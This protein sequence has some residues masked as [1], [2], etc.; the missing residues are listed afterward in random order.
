MEGRP[1]FAMRRHAAVALVVAV[2]LG[3]A[4][5]LG[6]STDASSMAPRS[7][8]SV[9]DARDLDTKA[10][11]VGRADASIQPDGASRTEAGEDGPRCMP[12][13]SAFFIA[14][15]GSDT[16][17]CTRTEPCLTFEKAQEMMTASSTVKTTY[18]RAGT[19]TRTI[20]YSFRT[21]EN[22]LGYPCDPP[23]SATIDA[24]GLSSGGPAFH[25]DGCSDV[26]MWNFTF[27]GAP[28]YDSGAWSD[29]NVLIEGGAND[30]HIDDNVFTGNLAAYDE[31]DI[32]SFDSSNIY[33]RGNTFQS[34][35]SGEPISTPYTQAGTY[36]GL[37]ITDNVIAGC[38]R[39]CIESQIQLA[40]ITVENLHIDRNTLKDFADPKNQCGDGDHYVG[41]ISA[42]GPASTSVQWN[43]G[44]TIWGNTLTAPS[45]TTS[46]IWGIEVGWTGTS[47]EYN[48]FADVGVA[49]AI[50]GMPGTEMENN[51]LT[52]ITSGSQQPSCGGG[53]CAFIEDGGYNGLEW[54]G[55]NTIDG[56]KVTGCASPFCAFTHAPYGTRPAVNTPSMPYD[57]S[58]P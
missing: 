26:V 4:S 32:Y 50:G 20:G 8:A 39:W 5:S 51:S 35:A 11:D 17:A 42:A 49:M 3:L 19:Y 18:A 37:F 38:Q 25:C 48:T 21:G 12:D 10:E 41:G 54:I 9:F 7:D 53:A 27:S 45:T 23:H 47:V 52:L 15:T 31:T 28:A 46:C 56:T 57:G 14:P 16:N 34:S 29:T 2:L 13:A 43:T 30:V 44:S 55:V 6:C 36:S 22:W 40:T 33:I 58:S 24:T 1:R